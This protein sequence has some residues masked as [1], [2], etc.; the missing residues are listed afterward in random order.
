MTGHVP[1]FLC[2]TLKHYMTPLTMNRFSPS[3]ES[4][5]RK[6]G[7]YPG[8]RVDDAQ[9]VQWSCLKFEERPGYL[10]IHPKAFHFLREFGGLHRNTI[11]PEANYYRD[12]LHFDPIE[13]IHL[14]DE[15]WFAEELAFNEVLFPIGTFEYGDLIMM[16][17]SGRIYGS[18]ERGDCVF[19]QTPE[20]GIESLTRHLFATDL[21]LKYEEVNAFDDA[22]LIYRAVCRAE[23]QS[24][25]SSE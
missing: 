24:N 6:M 13:Y 15:E 14:L 20:E 4:E 7:W 25:Q 23:G 12:D 2:Y 17:A 21:D 1:T 16:G 8:R 5:L 18:S 3:A 10:R 22:R 9:L 11:Q 19:G